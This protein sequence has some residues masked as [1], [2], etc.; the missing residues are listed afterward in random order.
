[1]LALGLLRGWVDGVQAFELSRLDEA[2]QEERWG[3]D[4]EAAERTARLHAEAAMLDRWFR[5]LA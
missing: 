3:V 1:M 4:D 5:N 2:W